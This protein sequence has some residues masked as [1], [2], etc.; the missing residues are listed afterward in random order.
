[1]K[2]LRATA[3]TKRTKANQVKQRMIES[4]LYLAEIG[5]QLLMGSQVDR[6]AVVMADE[7]A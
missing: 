4:S 7:D 2:D 5:Q 6:Q 3:K 1:M